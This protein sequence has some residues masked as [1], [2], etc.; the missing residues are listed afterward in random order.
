PSASHRADADL[1]LQ[2]RRCARPD[3]QAVVATARCVP[4]H[5]GGGRRQ[6]GTGP[7][8]KA[9]IWTEPNRGPSWSTVPRVWRYRAT[10][11]TVTRSGSAPTWRDAL[12][13][14]DRHLRG[15]R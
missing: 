1:G 13:A 3:P 4:G 14:V 6:P 2:P 5:V 15:V 10:R 7:M 9:A 12:T 11:G 8:S